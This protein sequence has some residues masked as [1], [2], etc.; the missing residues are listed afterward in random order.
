[1]NEFASSQSW[2]TVAAFTNPLSEK[3]KC[4]NDG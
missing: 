1:M 3:R 4:Q 2:S